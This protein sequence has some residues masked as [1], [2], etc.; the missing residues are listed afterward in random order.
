MVTDTIQYFVLEPYNTILCEIID[1]AITPQGISQLR[2]LSI[3]EPEIRC[4]IPFRLFMVVRN[5]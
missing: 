5:C 3:D 1:I 2:S 4:D